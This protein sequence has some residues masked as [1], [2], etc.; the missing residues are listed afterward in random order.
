MK[1]NG[2]CLRCNRKFTKKNL[3]FKHV[4]QCEVQRLIPLKIVLTPIDAIMSN[5]SSSASTNASTSDMNTNLEPIVALP[6]LQLP[7]SSKKAVE[8]KT[9]KEKRA[10]RKAEKKAEKKLEKIPDKKPDKLPD[11]KSERKLRKAPVVQLVKSEPETM[12]DT[13]G[14]AI[15]PIVSSAQLD[16]AST[17]MEI[18]VAPTPDADDDEA[19]SPANYSDAGGFSPAGAADDDSSDSESEIPE[20]DNTP[21]TDAVPT[22]ALPSDALPKEASSTDALLPEAS[23]TVV[24]QEPL[25]DSDDVIIIEDEPAEPIL[26]AAEHSHVKGKD[27]KSVEK[28]RKEKITGT[29]A[30]DGVVIKTEP[31]D[32]TET[33]P[34]VALELIDEI[35]STSLDEVPSTS[36]ATSLLD[37][38]IRIKLEPTDSNT[39]SL[40]VPTVQNAP[41]TETALAPQTKRKEKKS[42]HKHKKDKRT[43][44]EKSSRPITLPVSIAP[45]LPI[46]QEPIDT[47]YEHTVEPPENDTDKEESATEDVD[48]EVETDG[49]AGAPNIAIKTE[50]NR[51]GYDDFDPVLAQNI[52]KE[53]VD[54]QAT[55]SASQVAPS[56]RLKISK[57]HGTLNATII[58]HGNDK[59]VPPKQ[60]KTAKKSTVTTMPRMPVVT[61]L[62]KP[63][64]TDVH[65]AA[66][67]WPT[68]STSLSPSIQR[69]KD[70]AAAQKKKSKINKQVLLMQKIREEMMARIARE[71]EQAQTTSSAVAV[72]PSTVPAK[73]KLASPPSNSADTVNGTDTNRSRLP[74]KSAAAVIVPVISQVSAGDGTQIPVTEISSPVHDSEVQIKI[75][76]DDDGDERVDDSVTNSN[77]DEPEPSVDN[78]TSLPAQEN[79]PDVS[80]KDD[81]MVDNASQVEATV[82]QSQQQPVEEEMSNE[83]SEGDEHQSDVTLQTKEDVEEN[84][85]SLTT[86]AA[87]LAYIVKNEHIVDGDA[88]EET[89]PIEAE[90]QLNDQQHDEN[91]EK[92]NLDVELLTA[93]QKS[94]HEAVMDDVPTLEQVIMSLI[95]GYIFEQNN[96]ATSLKF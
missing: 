77:Q 88:N 74:T 17:I 6:K 22:T 45:L 44:T 86:E 79:L 10:E 27:K 42:K 13:D 11:K 41:T 8:K 19:A 53:Q 38:T 73:P 76:K 16:I 93:D 89:E 68:T 9:E 70:D 60:Q 55:S 40:P 28:T 61:P 84:A 39:N 33:G 56:L 51:P 87:Q 63:T 72:T 32:V 59:S 95:I 37:P 62:A 54:L 85:E 1:N 58:P 75:E 96:N 15:A 14:N 5:I 18:A 81:E 36:D 52:K 35:P 31:V 46:K 47:G 64:E 7:S 23:I 78:H 83:S 82:E 80:Q 34:A 67:V 90:P 48:N 49:S 92:T 25:D 50:P 24:K 43:P 69:N 66:S 57:T 2:H 65:T 29:A 71:K 20:S 30:V 4:V 3:L 91:M 12:L 94:Y 26:I 21:Q